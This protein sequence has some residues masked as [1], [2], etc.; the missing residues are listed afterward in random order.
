MVLFALTELAAEAAIWT[1]KKTLT[2]SWRG[3]WWGIS[4]YRGTVDEPTDQVT[5]AELRESV[6]KLQLQVE[7][8]EEELAKLLKND[9]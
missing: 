3:I 9:S 7:K 8:Q 1:L 4:K 6:Q 5:S 2:Y